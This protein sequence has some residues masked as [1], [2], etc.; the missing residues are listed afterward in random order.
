[1]HRRHFFARCGS[2]LG[3][4]G[5]VGTGCRSQHAHVITDCKQDMVG[6]C[7]AGAETYKPLV[8]EA[9]GK[10]L[11]RHASVVQ[12]VSTQP[13]GPKRICFVGVENRSVEEMGDFKEQI[14]EVIDTQIIESKVF[15]P[16]SRRFVD[17]GLRAVRLRP[18]ELFLPANQRAFLGVM[19]Q[20][21]QP[22]DYLLFAT[23]TSGT[24]RNNSDMQRDYLLTLELVDIK[25][26]QPDKESASLRKG[27]HKSLL[28]KALAY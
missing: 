8:N 22:F 20:Q 27:Y 1:M 4:A 12:Q 24:T 16:I 18:D 19:E 28:N 2:W 6:S 23:M 7:A 3:A 17:A 26:G 13:P 9:V 15:Q 10:L 14:T 11:A 5:L 25:S 21:G